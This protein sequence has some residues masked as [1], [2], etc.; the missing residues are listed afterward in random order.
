MA[1]VCSRHVD[2]PTIFLSPSRDSTAPDHA[3]KM[4]VGRRDFASAKKFLRGINGSRERLRRFCCHWNVQERP[5]DR[6]STS[7]AQRC[8]P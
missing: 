5:E 6:N 8:T 4:S 7:I 2:V 1:E 3:R